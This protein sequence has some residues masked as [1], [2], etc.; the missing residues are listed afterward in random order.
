MAARAALFV[1]CMATLAPGLAKTT[2]PVGYKCFK[3]PAGFK[4]VSPAPKRYELPAATVSGVRIKIEMIDC[5]CSSCN[6]TV[7]GTKNPKS[8]FYAKFHSDATQVPTP[9]MG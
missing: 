6:C 9:P 7:P 4:D 3:C 2:C 5:E 1:A 8:G